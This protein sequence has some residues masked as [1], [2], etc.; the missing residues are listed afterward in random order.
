MLRSVMRCLI[1]LHQYLQATF[2]IQWQAFSSTIFE[3]I[4]K[5]KKKHKRSKLTLATFKIW[6]ATF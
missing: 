1:I 5:G 2:K 6:L 3:I 4:Q